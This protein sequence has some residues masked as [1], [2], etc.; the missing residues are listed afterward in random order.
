MSRSFSK[1][2]HTPAMLALYAVLACV[3]L[4][5]VFVAA[6]YAFLRDIHSVSETLSVTPP[7]QQATTTQ[8]EPIAV[9]VPTS[10]AAVGPDLTHRPLAFDPTVRNIG[11]KVGP[12]T[13][14]SIQSPY[15][16]AVTSTTPD[17]YGATFSGKTTITGR[18]AVI[19]SDLA[20]D[21]IAFF[22]PDAESIL[23]VDAA[24]GDDSLHLS[25]YLENV[26][27]AV[28]LFGGPDVQG[29]ATIEIDGYTL[30]VGG[31]EAGDRAKLVRIVEKLPS[32]NFDPSF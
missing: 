32:N 24:Q 10:T 21:T 30:N 5:V 11:W 4:T 8:N 3:G 23:P 22:V 28:Q 13:L 14:V 16:E 12:L 17:W 7:A 6:R 19:H 2:K 27:K 9:P 20:G 1:T 29:R 25:F 15:G 18:Y 26:D 31:S